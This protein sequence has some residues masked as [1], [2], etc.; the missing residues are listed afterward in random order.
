M[1]TARTRHSHFLSLVKLSAKQ[2]HTGKAKGHNILM[3]KAAT[4]TNQTSPRMLLDSTS[5]RHLGKE[6]LYATEP[7]N[8]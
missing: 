3:L 5:A 1:A 4:D 2:Y 7:N 6:I 8:D